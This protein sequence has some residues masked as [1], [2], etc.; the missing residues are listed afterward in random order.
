S[1]AVLALR[2]I[3]ST[4]YVAGSFG[5][6]GGASRLRLAAIDRASGQALAWSADASADVECLDA[7]DA[8]LIAGGAFTAIGGATVAGVAEVWPDPAAGRPSA[9]WSSCP[10]C[11]SLKPNRPGA[12]IPGEGARPAAR[13]CGPARARATQGERD[14]TGDELVQGLEAR[15]A[16]GLEFE[17]LLEAAVEGVH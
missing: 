10:S 15:A 13:G 6:A 9:G 11:S 5:A 2:T 17:A 8:R 16:Q 1:D 3:G 7:I 4:V 12:D 14:M